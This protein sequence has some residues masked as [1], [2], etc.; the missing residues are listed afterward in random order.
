MK[1]SFFILTVFLLLVS[2]SLSGCGHK[3]NEDDQAQ[4]GA[5]QEEAFS[6][7]GGFRDL[8]SHKKSLRCQYVLEAED[9]RITGTTYTNGEQV[10]QEMLIEQDGVELENVMLVKDE[11]AYVWNPEQKVQG[12]KMNLGEFDGQTAEEGQEAQGAGNMPRY[13]RDDFQY[14][15]ESW[16]SDDSK[17]ELP[18][19][20]GFM[21]ITS[22]MQPSGITNPDE[23]E[24]AD[25][26]NH[27]Q[28]NLDKAK[29]R[30][31]AA[32]NMV[33]NQEE[34]KKNLNCE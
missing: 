30:A 11:T 22:M 20:R 5:G 15:C 33:P 26:K 13:M 2:L 25:V 34:C 23:Q 9:A 12:V 32:C 4:D 24:A 3:A 19:G 16:R 1:K 14:D 7:E 8:L 31:C 28:A 21:D 17:F 27:N 18:E 29:Q 6:F 10:R